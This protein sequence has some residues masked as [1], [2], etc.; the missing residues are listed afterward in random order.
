MD[1]KMEDVRLKVESSK[2]KGENDDFLTLLKN[3]FRLYWKNFVIVLWPIVLLPLLIINNT[4]MYRCLYVIVIMAMFWVTE[5]LPLPITGL[6]PI[7]LYP[8]MGILSTSKTCDCYMNDTT[9]MFIGSLVIAVVIEN[10]GLHMRLALLFIR[11]IGCS[12]RKLS[13]GL[14]FVTMFISMWISNTAAT[15]MMIPIMETVLVELEAQGLG[16]MYI[17]DGSSSVEEGQES[18]KRPTNSTMVY[19]L[20]AAYA[21]SLGGIG[22]MVG[23]GTNL[24]MKGIYESRFK[25]SPGISF[26][27]W[28]L[29][30][31]PPMLLMGF[32]T[33]LWLQVMYMGL[34]RS[35][36]KDAKA[37]D[38]GKQGEKVAADVIDR[39]YKELGPV[40][41]HESCVGF[42][43]V[44]VLL[45]WFFRSPGFIKGWPS[46]ITDLPVKDSTA[47]I[48]FTIL[49]FMIPSKLDFLNAFSKD[50]SKR[51]TRASPALMNWKT[52]HEKMHWSL[53]LVLGGG[54]AIAA[55]S[56]SSGLSVELGQTLQGLRFMNSIVILFLVCLFA[57]SV[58]ELTANVAVANIILPVLAEMCVAIKIHPLFLMLP[59]GICC[60]FSFH[61]PVGTPPNA[62]ASAAAHIKTRD[63]II[64]GI[65]PSIITLV[66]TTLAF[67]TWGVYVFDLHEFPEWA[68]MS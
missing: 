60:S 32:L 52:I 22:T 61:L 29:Y 62:I 47:A 21:S 37:I 46:F 13:L 66:V 17:Q 23:S 38:I 59:A 5:V 45:L 54:F 36:S 9:M 14:F 30:S 24:T 2:L 11:F 65:G 49:L 55:G 6:I 41:W 42:L 12:H 4:V 10:S 58:T 44:S 64:A 35:K 53:I 34:F 43:F 8:L 56:T 25:H 39:K 27:A 1:S 67:S 33:W 15:A 20:T 68:T 50:P 7:V 31:V 48:G 28:M 19:Y 16:N 40:T 57:E 18:E 3:F 26:A 51:P 63:F